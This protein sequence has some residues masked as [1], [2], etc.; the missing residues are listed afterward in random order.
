M[1]P[2]PRRCAAPDKGLIAPD[3]VLYLDLSIEES[4]KRGE[5]GNER[6]EKQEFQR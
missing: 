3:V 5:F 4:M 2:D 6:Y 1:C